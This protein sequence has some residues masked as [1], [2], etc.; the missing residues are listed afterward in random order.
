MFKISRFSSFSFPTFKPFYSFCT[1]PTP[2]Q[3]PNNITNF[4][5]LINPL[6]NYL[7]VDKTLFIK[8]ILAKRQNYLILRPQG[9]GKSLNLSMLE[10]FFSI[11]NLSNSTLKETFANLNI[12][13]EDNGSYLTKFAFQYPV[14][15]L[16]LDLQ[17]SNPNPSLI[18]VFY[19]FNMAISQAFRKHEYLIT[20]PNLTAEEQDFVKKICEEKFDQIPEE[21]LETLIRISLGKLSEYLYKHHGRQSIILIDNYDSPAHLSL[22]EGF[23]NEFIN[24]MQI[25]FD[26]TLAENPHLYQAV[27]M[28]I[29][30][31]TKS[32]LFSSLKTVTSVTLLNETFENHYGFTEKEVKSLIKELPET[33]DIDHYEKIYLHYKG[34]YSHAT[35]RKHIYNPYSIL[36]YLKTHKLYD[37]WMF[38]QGKKEQDLIYYLYTRCRP[39]DFQDMLDLIGK[40]FQSLERPIHWHTIDKLKSHPKQMG[41]FY[42]PVKIWS[43]LFFA[44]YLTLV[45][46]P[47]KQSTHYVSK[48]QIPN[49]EMLMMF[50]HFREKSEKERVYLLG[51]MKFALRTKDLNKFFSSCVAALRQRVLWVDFPRWNFERERH[52]H[53]YLEVVFGLLQLEEYELISEEKS[54]E[55]RVDII[56]L[57]KKDSRVEHAYIFELKFTEH[58]VKI[59]QMIAQALAQVSDRD[60]M[61]RIAEHSHVKEVIIAGVVGTDRRTLHFA[62]MKRENIAN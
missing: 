6:N 22:M 31:I 36:H 24:L 59:R 26:N 33:K 17:T 58:Q 61:R 1:I 56:L 21:N 2:R 50:K 19:S 44:G 14:I 51:E 8:D 4:S 16:N 28:G 9:F 48:L 53:D 10:S 11:N 25:F 12:G 42:N 60:Y 13:K 15:S 57:P 23:Y 45:D 34:Y 38:D 52:Y 39:H 46:K 29:M 40:K 54:G 35:K 5:H 20:S 47:V 27:I 32:Y 41:L 7:Y 55:G 37:F 3:I 43:L 62:S 18:D 49:T 30:P